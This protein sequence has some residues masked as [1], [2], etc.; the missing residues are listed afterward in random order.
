M[1]AAQVCQAVDDYRDYLCGIHI[2]GDKVESTNGHVAL[3]MTMKKKVRGSYIV[4]IGGKVPKKAENSKFEFDAKQ[5]VVKHFDHFGQFISCQPVELIEGRF[6]KITPL[7][8][9]RFSYVDGFGFNADYL[10]MTAK[11]F[12]KGANTSFQFSSCQKKALVTCYDSPLKDELGD[13]KFLIMGLKRRQ[14]Q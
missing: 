6:P 13:P 3:Q 2:S 7:M 8:P 9:E 11:I 14:K 1:R 12:G 10:A 4:K 5:S